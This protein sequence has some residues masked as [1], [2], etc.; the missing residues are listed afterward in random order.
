M[1]SQTVKYIAVIFL[2]VLAL[3][4]CDSNKREQSEGNK[5]KTAVAVKEKGTASVK[6]ESKLAE[7]F[8]DKSYPFCNS[9][10]LYKMPYQEQAEGDGISFVQYGIEKQNFVRKLFPK[11]CKCARNPLKLYWHS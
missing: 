2:T 9:T 8:T 11:D 10:N 5:E 7:K 6:K 3:T 4:A 1:R